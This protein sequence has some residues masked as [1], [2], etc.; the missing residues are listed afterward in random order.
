MVISY[1]RRDSEAISG[2]IRDRLVGAY[3]QDSVFMDIDSIPIGVNFRDYVAGALRDTDIMLVI[4]G[5]KWLGDSK[6]K[7][8]IQNPTDPVR[9]ELEKAFEHGIL[10]WPVLVDN[11]AM[12][13]PAS[14]PESLMALSDQNAATVSAGRDF[15]AHIDRLIRQMSAQLLASG[16]D[17]VGNTSTLKSVS[18]DSSHAA[19][20]SDFIAESKAPKLFSRAKWPIASLALG[21]VATIAIAWA[22]FT[23][24]QDSNVKPETVATSSTAGDL[25]LKTA[26]KPSS[27]PSAAST[28]PTTSPAAPVSCSQEKILRSLGTNMSTSITFTNKTDYVIRIY[29]LNFSGDRVL[30][31]TLNSG[32]ILSQQTYITHPWVVTNNSD[33][34]LAIYMPMPYAQ[35]VDVN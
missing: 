2:R 34:C 13:D 17:H 11:A 25:S 8:R 5:P 6:R 7:N 28:Q 29:W 14:L 12:P 23:R 19:Q 30:Y 18:A 33:Q 15:H 4:I 20:G 22:V 1:R 3:G 9:I 32:Q 27:S 21:V 24:L 26:T 16:T 35:Y 10:V 31:G